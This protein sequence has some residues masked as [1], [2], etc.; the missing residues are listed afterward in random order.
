MAEL[1]HMAASEIY[2]KKPGS[3]SNLIASV[4]SITNDLSAWLR[5]VPDRLRIDFS[6]LDT[7]INRESVSINLHFYSCVN[8]TA[9][10]LVFYVIQRRL[11]AEALGCATADWKDGLAPNTVAVIDSCITAA[12]A[13]TMIMDAAAK[14]NLIGRWLKQRFYSFCPWLPLIKQIL[15]QHMAISMANIYSLPHCCWSW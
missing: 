2:R 11:D 8:M 14:H 5:Q 9:R 7:H 6:T 13:T 10:P 3:G 1:I 15:K 4:Q 12:R